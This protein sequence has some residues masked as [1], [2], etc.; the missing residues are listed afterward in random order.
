MPDTLNIVSGMLD[1]LL[2]DG[3]DEMDIDSEIGHNKPGYNYIPSYYL[4]L[5]NMADSTY[6]TGRM[7]Y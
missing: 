2:A 1:N 5:Q 4:Y 6:D 3:H 7:K